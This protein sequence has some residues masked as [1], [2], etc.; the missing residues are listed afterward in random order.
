MYIYIQNLKLK[1]YIYKYIY[2]SIMPAIVAKV[3]IIANKLESL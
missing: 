2:T 3:L 1:I